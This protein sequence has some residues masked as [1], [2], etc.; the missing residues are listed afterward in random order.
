M[1]TIQWDEPKQETFRAEKCYTNI[2]T[3]SKANNKTKPMVKSKLSKTIEYFLSGPSY[4]SNKKRNAETMQQ[5]LKDFEEV[6]NDIG[7][8]DG[9]FSLQLKPDSKP[10]QV[11][12]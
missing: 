4:D 10:Y 1:N 6:F 8:F 3:I 12:L 7:Y 11:P 5:I 2:D 9:T